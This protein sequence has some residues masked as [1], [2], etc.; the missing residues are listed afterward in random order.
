MRQLRGINEIEVRLVEQPFTQEWRQ[1]HPEEDD[2][3]QQGP[4]SSWRKWWRANHHREASAVEQIV[5]F[6]FVVIYLVLA[7]RVV[8]Q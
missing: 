4:V 7:V 6:V 8:T 5:P 1:L 2:G 3:D